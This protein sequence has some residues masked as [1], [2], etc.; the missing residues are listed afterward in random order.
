MISKEWDTCTLAIVKGINLSKYDVAKS[1]HLFAILLP[2]NQLDR[3]TD[4]QADRKASD[5]GKNIID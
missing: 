4:R 2:A 5:Q 3:Q 1:K